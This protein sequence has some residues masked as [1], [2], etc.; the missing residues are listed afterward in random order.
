M[1][2]YQFKLPQQFDLEDLSFVL[3]SGTLLFVLSTGF[4]IYFIIKYTKAQ[5]ILWR[6]KIS[7]KEE[8][9]KLEQSIRTE[10]SENVRR[11]LH[12]SLGATLAILKMNLKTLERNNL[13]LDSDIVNRSVFLAEELIAQV[14]QLAAT[15]KQDSLLEYDLGQSI[16]RLVTSINETNTLMIEV[17]LSNEIENLP[18]NVCFHTFRIIQ[19][20]INN[21]L[22]HAQASQAN[23][24]IDCLND[25]I[26]L[27]Y[28]DNGLGIN[29]SIK[30]HTGGS[31]LKIIRERAE[32]LHASAQM[33]NLDNTGFSFTLKIPLIKSS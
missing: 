5:Q 17:K 21:T 24:T 25:E 7:A 18:A 26:M 23:L 1:E 30:T 16:D 12:D 28:Q 14:K 6:N 9:L 4:T 11:E 20:L 2:I 13:S 3:I 33:N 29:K 15:I 31:G 19:E 22:Q 8:H 32:I 10:I 27:T